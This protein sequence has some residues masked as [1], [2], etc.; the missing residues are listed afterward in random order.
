MGA[1]H[2]WL[3]SLLYN[4]VKFESRRLFDYM[5]FW[6]T[7]GMKDLTLCIRFPKAKECVIAVNLV[8]NCV[9][10]YSRM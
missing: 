9:S 7:L 3:S 1:T 6:L 8:D 10:W 4:N 2:T 5:C